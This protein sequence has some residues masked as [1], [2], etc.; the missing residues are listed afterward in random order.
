MAELEVDPAR[1]VVRKNGEVL[2]LSRLQ[3]TLLDY[4]YERQ[5]AVC[6]ADELI[7]VVYGEEVLPIEA[8]AD[9]RFER[10]IA[11]LREKIEDDPSNPAHLLTVPGRGYRLERP[12]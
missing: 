10:L 3:Y 6:P 4:L 9:K 12:V 8:S 1:Q 2:V 7:R 11:R 5:G